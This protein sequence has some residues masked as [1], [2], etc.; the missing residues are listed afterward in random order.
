M[1]VFLRAYRDRKHLT[2][3]QVAAFMGIGEPAIYRW[4]NGQ[5]SPSLRDVMRLAQ[6]YEISPAAF[7]IDPNQPAALSRH[8]VI[9]EVWAKAV[10]ISPKASDLIEHDPDRIDEGKRFDRIFQI[11]ERLPKPACDYWISQGE[12]FPLRLYD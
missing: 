1:S 4:E 6:L 7:F 10:G 9:P 8:H 3:K 2:R 12:N 11:V 5:A